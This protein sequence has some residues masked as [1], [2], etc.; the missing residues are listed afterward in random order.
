MEWE[1]AAERLA[2]RQWLADCLLVH[3]GRLRCFV[4]AKM[5]STEE[6]ARLTHILNDLVQLAREIRGDQLTPL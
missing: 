5:A 3:E 1:E 4:D 6:R 2:G